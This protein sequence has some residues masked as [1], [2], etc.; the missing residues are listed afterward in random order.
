M[1]RSNCIEE[2]SVP[3][4]DNWG[5]TQDATTCPE[6]LPAPIFLPQT[7][8]ALTFHTLW[9]TLKTCLPD[10]QTGYGIAV[11]TC[12]QESKKNQFNIYINVCNQIYSSFVTQ[13]PHKNL[14]PPYIDQ[15]HEQLAFHLGRC[16]NSHLK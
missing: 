2:F 14:S 12:S 9:K 11:K 5:P 16:T 8:F 4:T 6:Q 3:S 1:I 10:I 13:V 7:G 15:G